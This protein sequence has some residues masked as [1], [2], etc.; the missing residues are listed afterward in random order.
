MESPMSAF[1]KIFKVES[2]GESGVQSTWMNQLKDKPSSPIV[3]AIPPEFEGPGGTYSPEDLYALSLLNC[4]LATFKFIAEKSKLSYKKIDAEATLYVD[5][6]DEK[7]PWMERILLSITLSG[8]AD[9]TRSLNMLE[10]TKAHC[11]ILNSVKTKVDFE[12]SAND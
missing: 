2:S 4:Y 9:K 7:A 12:F 10:K 11:M 8:C 5:R 6:G 1:P 3:M